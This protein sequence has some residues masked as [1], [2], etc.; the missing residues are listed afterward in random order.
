RRPSLSRSGSTGPAAGQ[1][2]LLAPRAR[3]KRARNSV[4]LAAR[5]IIWRRI[6]SRPMSKLTPPRG[7]GVGSS[8]APEVEALASDV[9]V[10]AYQ[11]PRAQEG[12]PRQAEVESGWPGAIQSLTITVVIALFIITFLLQAFQIPSP[13]MENTLLIGDY[14]LVDKL[15]FS[16]GGLGKAILPYSSVQRGD[17]IVF[18]YPV[19][20]FQHFVKRVV[21]LPGDRVRIVNKR[22]L[23][24]GGP[25]NDKSY[26]ISRRAS[27]DSFRDNFPNTNSPPA[28]IY[29]KWW[30]EMRRQV[31]G[32]ELIVPA[33]S[34]FVLGDNRDDSFDSRYWGFVPQESVTGRPL[35][36]YWSMTTPWEGPGAAP[37]PDGKLKRLA[38]ALTHPW[39]FTRWDRTLRLVK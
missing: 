33:G 25:V 9:G 19:Y 26:A 16:E 14:L 34:F 2:T 29:S 17:I 7:T 6:R 27:L 18:H 8:R 35:I 15:H 22:V 38:S 31:R 39:Q 24:N 32:G 12:S 21:G 36:I 4:Q 37:A 30:V 28:D 1:S 23:L 11:K 3:A 5:W 20:P 13:S 10:S